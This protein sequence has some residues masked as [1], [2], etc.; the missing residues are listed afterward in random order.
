MGEIIS[1][2]LTTLTTSNT[3][4]TALRDTGEGGGYSTYRPLSF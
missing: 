3:L 2:I 4:L 1:P